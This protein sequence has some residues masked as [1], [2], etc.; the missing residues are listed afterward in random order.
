MTRFFAGVLSVIAVGVMLIAYG[1]LNPRVDAFARGTGDP[2]LRPLTPAE[3][4]A[5]RVDPYGRVYLAPAAPAY[6][7]AQPTLL[8]TEPFDVRRSAFDVQN[9]AWRTEHGERT[10]APS[11]QA[12]APRVVRTSRVERA[13]KRDWRRTALVVGGSTATGA[14]VG[15]IFGGRK[16]A[17]IGAA[18]GGGAST[19]YESTK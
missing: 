18:I 9:G 14:G 2:F 12:E 10:L 5:L 16:G 7:Y 8:T 1:L 15:A 6:G 3:Q 11:V 4:A 13:G 17:L 19:L